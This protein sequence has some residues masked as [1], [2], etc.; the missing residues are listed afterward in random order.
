MTEAVTFTKRPPWLL[1]CE[2][3]AREVRGQARIEDAHMLREPDNLVAW[4]RALN[5]IRNDVDAHMGD[6]RLRLQALKP[7]PGEYPSEEYLVA[8]REYERRH[9]GRVR[10]KRGVEARLEEVK[11]LLESAGIDVRLSVGDLLSALLRI[12]ELLTRDDIDG[13]LGCARMYLKRVTN[14]D[15]IA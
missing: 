8:K 6:A 15:E 7:L 9:A 4:A 3:V 14:W 13:A 5:Q 2:L 1:W 12:E 10:F 11:H